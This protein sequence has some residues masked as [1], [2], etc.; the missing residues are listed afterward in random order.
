MVGLDVIDDA[1]LKWLAEYTR[2]HPWRFVYLE[3]TQTSWNFSE[4]RD[5]CVYDHA[6]PPVER[7]I[8]CQEDL[9]KPAVEHL[10]PHHMQPYPR[11]S[12]HCQLMNRKDD[13]IQ[14]LD[15]E[16][17]SSFTRSFFSHTNIE[18]ASPQHASIPED[19]GWSKFFE[20]G[21]D[22]YRKTVS[23]LMEHS[24]PCVLLLCSPPGA[25]KTHFA[26]DLAE[27]VKTKLG[28][29]RAFIDGSDDRLVDMALAEILNVELP[30]PTRCQFLIVVIM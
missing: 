28:L 11:I 14:S 3:N 21:Q 16:E 7:G 22:D 23:T 29:R 1:L 6:P 17:M 10:R 12:S 27:L 4:N 24:E 13:A 20:I 18:F 30:D 5:R 19:K 15:W 8:R 2:A 25:G 26:N 9:K